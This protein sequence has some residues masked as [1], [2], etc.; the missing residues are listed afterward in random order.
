MLLNQVYGIDSTHRPKKR[1]WRIYV[2][3]TNYTGSSAG[4]SVSIAEVTWTDFYGVSVPKPGTVIVTADS[5][6]NDSYKASK[7]YDGDTSSFWSG[8][9]PAIPGWIKFDFG[10]GSEFCMTQVAMRARNDSLHTQAPRDFQVQYSDN[11]TTWTTYWQKA[12][13]TWSA[14]LQ[15]TFTK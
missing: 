10:S 3:D 1:F 14:G 4:D 2:T 13:V 6:Y 5:Q 11:G 7:A 12:G 9:G 15:R 8:L